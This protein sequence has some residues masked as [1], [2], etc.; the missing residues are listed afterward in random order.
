MILLE[1]TQIVPVDFQL[2]CNMFQQYTQSIIFGVYAV[3]SGIYGGVANVAPFFH[4]HCSFGRELTHLLEGW[5]SCRH[6]NVLLGVAYSFDLTLS[7]LVDI[8]F[9]HQFSRIFW[10][11]HTRS[12]SYQFVSENFTLV[13]FVANGFVVFPVPL[14]IALVFGTQEVSVVYST[15]L[16]RNCC[17][18]RIIRIL[19]RCT[20]FG[21]SG[22]YQ[23]GPRSQISTAKVKVFYDAERVHP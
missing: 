11:R 9:E 21:R 4:L 16:F 14:S 13:N 7:S 23:R 8:F 5:E 17:L 3:S 20:N 19:S 22:A 2:S 1:C 12:I 10:N 15:L 18:T 6:L